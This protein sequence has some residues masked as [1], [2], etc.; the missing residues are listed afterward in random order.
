MKDI[1][2]MAETVARHAEKPYP[3]WVEPGAYYV[4]MASE[5]EAAMEFLVN[6][7]AAERTTKT[8]MAY[9]L[10]LIFGTMIFVIT[11][12]IFFALGWLQ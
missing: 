12:C 1:H 3:Q 11:V 5:I 2:A 10:Q 9:V 4:S 6:R 7:T 8:K